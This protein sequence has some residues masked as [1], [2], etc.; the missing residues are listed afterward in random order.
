MPT[1]ARMMGAM[2][3]RLS[4]VIPLVRAIIA[5]RPHPAPAGPL[6]PLGLWDARR[7]PPM[8]RLFGGA[9]QPVGWS[10]KV[11]GGLFLGTSQEWATNDPVWY[12]L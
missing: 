9:G 1:I 10:A 5:P 11:L 4:H 12:V 8:M 6:G 2:L 7:L 3:L